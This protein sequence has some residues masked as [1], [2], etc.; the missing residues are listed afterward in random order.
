[1][2]RKPYELI[3]QLAIYSSKSLYGLA[4]KP[5]PGSRPSCNQNW[6]E[7]I[8]NGLELSQ[9]ENMYSFS[10]QPIQTFLTLVVDT[11]DPSSESTL[12]VNKDVINMNN[13]NRSSVTQNELQQDN[14]RSYDIRLNEGLNFIEF[15]C[16]DSSKTKDESMKFWVNVLP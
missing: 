5:L 13:N 14:N 4:T 3:K 12:I 15:K 2:Q 6:V 1:M 16:K 11:A 8:F 9:N 7:F 10:L